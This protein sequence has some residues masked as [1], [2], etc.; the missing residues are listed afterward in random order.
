M[1]N[2]SVEYILIEPDR[3]LKQMTPYGYTDTDQRVECV[4][5]EDEGILNL[6]I[7]NKALKDRCDDLTHNM[8]AVHWF[9]E[10]TIKQGNKLQAEN[11][12][13]KDVIQSL[14]TEVNQYK[15]K[16]IKEKEN[17]NS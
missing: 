1:H 9:H 4:Y 10:N 11:I 17:E 12:N 3:V 14:Q 13:L 5:I 15:N 7:K 16:I 6:L 2:K 8:N